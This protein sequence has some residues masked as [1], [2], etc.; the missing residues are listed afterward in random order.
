MKKKVLVVAVGLVVMV[1]LISFSSYKSVMHNVKHKNKEIKK[2]SDMRLSLIDIKKKVENKI[3]FMLD[4]V[5]NNDATLT[6]K[7]IKS[8]IQD[9]AI[10]RAYGK[11]ISATS[12]VKLLKIVKTLAKKH[13]VANIELLKE[14][15][16]IAITSQTLTA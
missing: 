12:K 8:L 4:N 3:D 13:D 6:E 14:L 11:D 5:E 10:I 7:E 16:N 15:K 1:S 9:I 2:L